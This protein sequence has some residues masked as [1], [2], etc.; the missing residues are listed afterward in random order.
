MKIILKIAVTSL[1]FYACFMPDR[2]SDKLKEQQIP[3][4][5]GG[6]TTFLCPLFTLCPRKWSL[7]A[8]TSPVRI[9]P[10]NFGGLHKCT[11]GNSLQI[12]DDFKNFLAFKQ[13]IK[14]S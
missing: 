9:P 8:Q 12:T 3:S 5:L 14:F 6:S 1:D 13:K 4:L 7:F 11:V 10:M 2:L